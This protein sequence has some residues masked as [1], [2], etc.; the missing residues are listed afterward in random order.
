MKRAVSTK[1]LVTCAVATSLLGAIVVV[2]L[3]GAQAVRGT[4]QL[5][6]F[7]LVLLLLSALSLRGVRLPRILV[8]LSAIGVLCGAIIRYSDVGLEA[9]AFGVARFESDPLENATRIFRDRV[10]RFMGERSLAKF[11]VIGL[12]IRSE[13]EARDALKERPQ[14]GGI[15]WGGERWVSVSI[16]P[17]AP[18]SLG[19]L[20][21][22]SFA[23]KRL[24]ELGVK[25]LRI[26]S[27]APGFGISKALDAATSE[28]VGRFLRVVPI[29]PAALTD[30]SDSTDLELH[31]M[32][33]VL[34]KAHWTTSEHIAAPKWMLGTLY[35][36]RAISGPELSWGDLLCAEASLRSARIIAL[37]SGGNPALTSAILN[38]ESV[39]QLLKAGHSSKPNE[40]ISHARANL[41]KALHLRKRS[42]VAPLEP[43]Y[44]DPIS[45]NLKALGIPDSGSKKRR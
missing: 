4:V 10:R 5:A 9:G 38:N 3:G 16:P 31:L 1:T 44:W 17:A 32:S 20:P 21:Q 35:L 37:K 23:Q 28:F 13:S 24:H 2:A 6:L 43:H 15:V 26:I 14:L 22:S 41:V 19:A 12:N 29:F 33:A 34:T 39:L 27:Q 40:Q 36:M 8:G 42:L 18:V 11:G 45:F 7:P 25:D 30:E